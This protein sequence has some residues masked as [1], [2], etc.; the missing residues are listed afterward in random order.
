MAIANLM[1]NTVSVRRQPAIHPT[2]YAR[3]VDLAERMRAICRVIAPARLAA[4]LDD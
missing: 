2:S 4:Q 3:D 1:S